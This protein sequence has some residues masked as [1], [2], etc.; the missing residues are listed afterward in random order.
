MTAP[1]NTL[2][3]GQIQRLNAPPKLAL[4]APSFKVMDEKKARS[5]DEAAKE[6]SAVMQELLV[7]AMVRLW[8]QERGSERRKIVE[9][10]LAAV[11]LYNS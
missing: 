5:A 6:T 4:H 3:S 9:E 2:R 8:F 7:G 10:L 1:K 11:Q